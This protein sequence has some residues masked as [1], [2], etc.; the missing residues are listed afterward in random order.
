MLNSREEKSFY[1]QVLLRFIVV[2]RLMQ[3]HHVDVP[4]THQPREDKVMRYL[5]GKLLQRHLHLKFHGKIM[6]Y[7]SVV[8]RIL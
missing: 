5:N 7:G 4:S 3:S 8:S 1:T 2:K 6:I